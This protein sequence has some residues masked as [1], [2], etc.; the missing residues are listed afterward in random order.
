M[1]NFFR[2][3]I[4]TVDGLDFFNVISLPNVLSMPPVPDIPTIDPLPNLD[5]VPPN[6]EDW[7][8]PLNL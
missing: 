6:V 8:A 5:M 7:F 2:S 4:G 1:S 3:L